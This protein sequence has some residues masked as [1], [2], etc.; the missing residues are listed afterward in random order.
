MVK[1]YFC[2]A[3]LFILSIT[4]SAQSKKE[5]DSLVNSSQNVKVTKAKHVSPK[6]IKK[7]KEYMLNGYRYQR[8][9]SKMSE[10]YNTYQGF[11]AIKDHVITGKINFISVTYG[12]TISPYQTGQGTVTH[13][14]LQKD[15][16][17]TY[18]HEIFLQN[19]QARSYLEFGRLVDETFIKSN[20]IQS[21][22]DISKAALA[23]TFEDDPD[24]V[25]KVN[26]LTK[27]KKKDLKAMVE[28]YNLNHK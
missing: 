4:A 22:L 25:L 18:L 14:Y 26:Q 19:K 9:V 23:E 3:F 16:L 10:G 17:G 28:E 27:L 24:L 13:Y 21:Y 15:G 11:Y 7:V 1:F 8:D 5:S 2:I 12:A 20:P 6:K